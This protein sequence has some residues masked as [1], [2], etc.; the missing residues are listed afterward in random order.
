VQVIERYSNIVK[1]YETEK[2][3]VSSFELRGICN[4]PN[5]LKSL[6]RDLLTGLNYLHK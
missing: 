6:A 2:G 5:A 4:D 1:D 3:G